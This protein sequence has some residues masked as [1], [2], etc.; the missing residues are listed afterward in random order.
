MAL[1]RLPHSKFKRV[2]CTHLPGRCTLCPTKVVYLFCE[3]FHFH[4]ILNTKQF[5]SFVSV[6]LSTGFWCA[7]CLSFLLQLGL[8]SE[9]YLLTV[10]ILKQKR[11][12]KSETNGNEENI[13][14]MSAQKQL[15]RLLKMGKDIGKKIK[16]EKYIP[17]VIIHW[18]P[19][20]V[21]LDCHETNKA[22]I[23]FTFLNFIENHNHCY[24][25]ML[26]KRH[27]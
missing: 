11:S 26:H 2:F 20:N 24:I 18:S 23:R 8:N 22:K 25:Q 19:H 12:S 27:Y 5:I 13:V 9:I 14:R 7:I 4:F 10:G 6:L 3:F 15:I 17:L 1:F 16:M 21:I